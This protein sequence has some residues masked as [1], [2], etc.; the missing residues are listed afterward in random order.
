M[1]RTSFY[2]S[3]VSKLSGLPAKGPPTVVAERYNELELKHQQ[4]NA[5]YSKLEREHR[6]L[7]KSVEIGKPPAPAMA[8]VKH[9][10]RKRTLIAQTADN[11][12]TYSQW[13]PWE[14]I[15]RTE[16]VED[17]TNPEYRNVRQY[18]VQ[19]N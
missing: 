11:V 7:L 9:M 8:S 14:R 4:L 6:E 1:S 16:Y 3:I 10:R 17:A 5:A 15:S 18:R 13:G 12:Q 19:S 2:R